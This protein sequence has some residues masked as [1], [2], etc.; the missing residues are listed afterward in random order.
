M[1]DRYALQDDGTW[2]SFDAHEYAFPGIP[3]LADANGGE[4][5]VAVRLL[6]LV[7]TAEYVQVLEADNVTN[8]AGTEV[9]T[10]FADAGGAPPLVLAEAELL[11]PIVNEVEPPTDSSGGSEA[12]TT[13]DASET[14]SSG[15]MASTRGSSTSDT[16]GDDPGATDG[17]GCGC[18]STPA[19]GRGLGPLALLG[20]FA[21][22]PRRPPPNGRHERS[23]RA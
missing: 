3:S 4:L 16:T 15:G 13:T 18:R 19:H 12:G 8:T 5:R 17:G 9:A 7:N 1:T 10:R 6:Y 21:L 23:A 11:V 14:T 20:L 22:R 2:P